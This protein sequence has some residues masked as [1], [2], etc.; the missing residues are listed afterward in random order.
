MYVFEQEQIIINKKL[1]DIFLFFSK[2]ENLSYLT[3]N[4]LKFKIN[5]NSDKTMKEGAKFYYTI[6]LYGIP[7]RWKTIITKYEP[8][9]LFTD[10]QETGPY[11]KWIHT[12]SF[13]VKNGKTIMKDKIEFDLYGGILKPIIYAL[14]V[15]KSVKQIFEYRRKILEKKFNNS[16]PPL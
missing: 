7:L 12:H 9:F 2:P 8:P 4:W 15:K 13:E 16:N 6:K 3:P 11:K 1:K 5:S 14:F 10:V